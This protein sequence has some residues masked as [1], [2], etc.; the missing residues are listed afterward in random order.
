MKKLLFLIVLA[1]P[2]LS[3]AQSFADGTNLV[4]I[5]F[6]LPPG[7]VM[8][9][10]N[11]LEPNYTDLHISNYGTG[12]L[13]YEHGFHKYFGLGL[14]LEYSGASIKYNYGPNLNT[15]YNA[16]VTR[17]VMGGYVRFN[18]HFPVGD[19]VDLYGGF[20]LGYLYTLDISK[21]SNP[22]NTTSTTYN[23]RSS[24]L[25]FS[26][27]ITAGIRLMVKDGFGIFAEFGYATTPA[28]LGV[29]LKF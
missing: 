5:G 17:S 18:G 16:T 22:S 21:D 29:V 28:Q 2:L 23:H 24:D 13:K 15:T 26:Y 1:L 9:N 8:S 11:T 3:K 19:K 25:E 7:T 4:F 10:T 14:N 20:G 27:Q 6:G 12:V